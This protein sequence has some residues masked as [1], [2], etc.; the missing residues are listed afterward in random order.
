MENHTAKH[1][2]LQLGSLAS[3]YLSL[4]FFIVLVFALVNLTFP[5]PLDNYW[6][7]EDYAY[8]V[9]L[10]FA[11]TVV[12]FPTYLLLTRQVNQNRRQSN[13]SSYLTL[14]K[15]LIYLS[16][17]V[18]GAVLLGDLVAV[19]LGFLEGGL[20]TRFILKALAVFLVT[21]FAFFYYLQDA[22]GYWIKNQTQSLW[23]AAI[24]TIV[25]AGTLVA[26]LAHIQ[27]PSEVRE[28]K[29]DQKM[30]GDLQDMQWRIEDFARSNDVLPENLE[31][32]Y[33]LMSVPTPPESEAPYEY[34]VTGDDTYKL[35]ATF[36]HGMTIRPFDEGFIVRDIAMEPGMAMNYNW[37]YKAGYWCFERV[38]D[39]AY[40]Q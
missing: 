24:A 26:S 37:D 3:L 12:F 18:G 17:L 6:Q 7:I 21:G 15:W 39:D 23:C 5:D 4:S 2:A 25:I 8:M 35:C 19:I 10:G 9:R 38:I 27:T 32:V 40:R 36:N 13:D 28:M 20:S 29:T 30:L 14:T 22:K 33:G 34:E 1:F 31:Q 11:M 16:L